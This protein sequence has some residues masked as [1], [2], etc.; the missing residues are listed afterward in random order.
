[1]S[2]RDTSYSLLPCPFCGGTDIQERENRL[3][4]QMSGEPGALVSVDIQHW[5]GGSIREG[6]LTFHARG[7]EHESARR[8][9]N[10]RAA[11]RDKEGAP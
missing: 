11:Q 4:P 6:M 7:H 2:S 3:S 1:M 8:A 9:W 10:T 5:C